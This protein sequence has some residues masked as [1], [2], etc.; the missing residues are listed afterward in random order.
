MLITV[1]GWKAHTVP[2]PQEVIDVITGIYILE[3]L[4]IRHSLR[5]EVRHLPIIFLAINISLSA[6]FVTA[7]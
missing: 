6:F 4:G 2:T 1:Q 3:R 5:Q 7:G